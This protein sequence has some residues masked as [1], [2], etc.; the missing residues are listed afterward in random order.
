[1]LVVAGLAVVVV[2]TLQ[3]RP[4][5]AAVRANTAA[6]QLTA[7]RNFSVFDGERLRR[8]LDVVIDDGRVSSIMP[9][10]Q[11]AIPPGA[12]IVEGEGRT[13]LPGLI[14][15]H[16][17]LFSA[18]EKEA[19]P[20]SAGAIA[21]AFVYAGVTTVLVAAGG[22][23]VDDVRTAVAAG[24]IVGPRLYW[25][26]PGLTTVGG[27]PIPLL[28]AMLPWPL[29]AVMVRG[30]ITASDAGEA[31]SRV[32][33]IVEAESPD[34]IKIIYD[35]LPPGSPHLGA[36]ELRAAID[37]ALELG[38][39]PVVHATTPED[40]V[41]AAEAGAALLVHIP[42]RGRVSEEHVA[43]LKATGVPFATTVRLISASWELAERGPTK[44]ERESVDPGQLAAWQAAPAWDLPG[45]SEEV[46]ER[47]AEVAADAQANFRSLY[48][49]GVT[50]LVGTDSGVHGVFPGSSL[51]RELALLVRLG[52]TP[53]D[54]LRGVTSVPADFLE[55]D[56]DFGR[57]AAG[58]RADLIVVRGDPTT[59]IGA[60]E[61]LEE[62]FVGG[63]RVERIPVD[64]R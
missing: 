48:R 29:S 56:P 57:I 36:E 58:M 43:R 46:D 28:R 16:S 61:N 5:L 15:S 50:L 39:R 18:G 31:A 21:Q 64:A 10:G 32:R 60:L 12:V 54:A 14:D 51:H 25:A 24:E 41:L 30:V 7:F 52:M 4:R 6:P 40:C 44:L 2:A 23:E 33:E 8:D 1:M 45:F 3:G 11:L 62:V 53:V 9:A 42:Q 17:H 63:V 35:D 38:V 27:H 22:P 59:D 19:L 47:H 49:A 55:E 37:T 26:G 13:L 34:L 20:P